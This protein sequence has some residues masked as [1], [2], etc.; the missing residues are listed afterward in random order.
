MRSLAESRA[1]ATRCSMK[2]K[3]ERYD[4]GRRRSRRCIARAPSRTN[5][6]TQGATL[7]TLEAVE[8]RQAGLKKLS[9]AT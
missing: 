2:T 3:H 4:G 5:T 9:R 1:C 7:D 8:A 6:A